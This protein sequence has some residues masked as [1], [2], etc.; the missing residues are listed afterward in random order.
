MIGELVLIAKAL[1]ISNAELLKELGF[2]SLKDEPIDKETI[3]YY[4]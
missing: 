1:G 2:I 3:N 4:L